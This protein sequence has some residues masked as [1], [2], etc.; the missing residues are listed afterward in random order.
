MKEILLEYPYKAK[1]ASMLA[2]I[3]FFGA[4]AVVGVSLA[5]TNDRGL[6]LNGIF[7]FSANGATIFY[8]CLAAA[9]MLFVL[10]AI[11]ALTMNLTT[12][13]FV[14]LTSSELS[15]PP[16]G[17]ARQPVV[18]ALSDITQVTIQ[19]IQRHQ[20]LNIHHRNGKSTLSKSMLPNS[21]AFEK[22][23][24]ALVASALRNK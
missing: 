24:A 21:D 20:F 13:R 19:T 11:L 17:F 2:G 1:P 18:I 23:N 22:L 15:F 5:V 6:I 16:Y 9:S 12:P 8:W 14:R 7:R 10:V 3:A 4:C